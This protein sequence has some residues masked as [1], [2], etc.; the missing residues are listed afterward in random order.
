MTIEYTQE[1]LSLVIDISEVGI[2]FVI[3]LECEVYQIA[4]DYFSELRYPNN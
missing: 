1:R 3:L 2:V 4:D